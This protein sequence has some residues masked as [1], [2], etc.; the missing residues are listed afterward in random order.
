MTQR[1]RT[2]ETGTLDFERRLV[3]YAL[4]GSAVLGVPAVSQASTLPVSVTAGNNYPVSFDK[5][6]T[7]FTLN[8]STSVVND[9]FVDAVN[10]AEFVASGTYPTALNQGA[11]IYSGSPTATGGTLS[12]LISS[13]KGH[14]SNTGSPA[15]LGVVFNRTSA[16]Y[17]GW[18]EI[19][20]FVNTGGASA[21]LIAYSYNPT[22]GQGIEAGQVFSAT[23][24]PS[25][26]ALY[27]FG[28]AG[29]L[30]LRRRRK[31]AA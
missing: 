13:Y 31:L 12:V 15:Y 3:R 4:A 2:K 21:D 26:L 5:T 24:E 11:Y 30:A 10:G 1:S 23:P 18:A 28:A 22:A 29:I 25:T 6:Q 27:A 16:T 7:D 20:A 17:Y 9:V 14:W 19:E 8:A